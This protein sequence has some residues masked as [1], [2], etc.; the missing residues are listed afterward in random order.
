MIY[1]RHMDD[2]YH[3]KRGRAHGERFPTVG[4]ALYPKG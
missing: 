4:A 2:F 3:D 1:I